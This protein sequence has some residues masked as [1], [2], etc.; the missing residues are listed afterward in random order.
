[1]QFNDIPTILRLGSYIIDASALH[2]NNCMFVAHHLITIEKVF[3]RDLLPL[4]SSA[5][6]SNQTIEE[7]QTKSQLGVLV[8]RI[9]RLGNEGFGEHVELKQKEMCDNLNDANG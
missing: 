8:S 4:P 3:R 9:R 5:S 7:A 2:H 1:M 6:S